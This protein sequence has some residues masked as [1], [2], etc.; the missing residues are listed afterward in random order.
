METS[1]DGQQYDCRSATKS[2]SLQLITSKRQA[3]FHFLGNGEI[4]GKLRFLQV[5][6]EKGGELIVQVGRNAGFEPSG[7]PF[8]MTFN[9]LADF[10]QA[11]DDAGTVVGHRQL[12]EFTD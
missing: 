11:S 6:H 8:V 2:Q 5:S 9:D 1:R 12:Q 10:M 4:L 7:F 3:P